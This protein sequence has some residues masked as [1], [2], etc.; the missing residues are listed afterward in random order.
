M[1]TT[2]LTPKG[3]D[4]CN[5][6]DF[7][8][9]LYY[10]CDDLARNPGA[11][12]QPDERSEC[13]VLAV[14]PRA[15]GKPVGAGEGHGQLPVALRARHRHLPARAR[16]RDVLRPDQRLRGD[17]RHSSPTT[18]ASELRSVWRDVAEIC[19]PGAQLVVRFGGIND[20]KAEALTI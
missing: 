18:F 1:S 4:K 5:G 2:I 9:A 19:V 15:Q 6:E 13:R 8:L 11:P 17:D 12:H 3:I 14:V 7:D 16:P 20:R 10:H